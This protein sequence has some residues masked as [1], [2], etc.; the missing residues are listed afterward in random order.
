[1]HQ[2][3]D[4]VNCNDFLD[5]FNLLQLA[6][7]TIVLA[8]SKSSFTKKAQKI[9]QYSNKKDLKINEDK[10]KYLHMGNNDNSCRESII[11]SDKLQIKAVNDNEGYNWLG[12]WLTHTNNVKNLIKFNLKKKMYNIA[13]F[14][15]WIQLNEDTPFKIKLNVLYSCLPSLLLYSSEAWGDI[16][17]IQKQILEIERK[18][19][20]A[21]LGVKLGTSED[22][23]YT[24]I[25]RADIIAVIKDRQHKFINKIIK[26]NCE[27]AVVS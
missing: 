2:S 24:E 15:E 3:V 16:T 20:K 5:P 25:N 8:E 27:E 11:I 18:A 22:I 4:E 9:E 10:T 13:K 6:D 23:I 19:I 7:N 14:Y 26:L 17:S 12:F 21:L 1:M